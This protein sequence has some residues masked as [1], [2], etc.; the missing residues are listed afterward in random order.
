MSTLRNVF[1]LN[2]TDFRVYEI[3][4]SK[5]WI[6]LQI[7]FSSNHSRLS[8]LFLLY[9]FAFQSLYKKQ[10]LFKLFFIKTQSKYSYLSPWMMKP[11]CSSRKESSFP[12]EI[13][14]AVFHFPTPNPAPSL[15][16]SLASPFWVHG[17]LLL[18]ELTAWTGIIQIPERL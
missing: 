2:D 6:W 10:W 1:T 18:T 4:F 8:L 11:S 3:A 5:K 9:V 7:V 12:V 14:L 13:Q 17:F 15:F 16:E